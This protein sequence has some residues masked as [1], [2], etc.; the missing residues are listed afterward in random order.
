MHHVCS[1]LPLAKQRFASGRLEQTPLFHTYF[2]NSLNIF[3][4]GMVPYYWECLKTFACL[5]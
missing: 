3:E 4:P 5:W 1:S 2:A